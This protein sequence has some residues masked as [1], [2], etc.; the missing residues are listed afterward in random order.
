M[1]YYYSLFFLYKKSEKGERMEI[2]YDKFELLLALFELTQK[3]IFNNEKKIKEKFEEFS[4]E[5]YAL[6]PDSEEKIINKISECN[7]MSADELIKSPDYED[8][9]LKYAESLYV[10]FVKKISEKFEITEKQ[11][12]A[13]IAWSQDLI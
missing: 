6:V 5:M 4:S 3:D 2:P 8:L 9:R 11:A 13:L 1:F 10:A 12:W 7:N